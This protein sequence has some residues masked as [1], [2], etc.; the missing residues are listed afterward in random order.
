MCLGVEKSLEV[1]GVS[2]CF[3][4]CVDVTF[5]KK[6]L[7]VSN[8][9]MLGLGSKVVCDVFLLKRVALLI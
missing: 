7:A 3:Q 9:A 1:S 5:K 6:G 8:L 4:V 2:F